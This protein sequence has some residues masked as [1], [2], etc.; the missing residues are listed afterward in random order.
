MS[1]LEELL[2]GPKITTR[3]LRRALLRVERERRKKRSELKRLEVRQTKTL[4]ELKEARRTGNQ[5]EVDYLWEDLKATKLDRQVCLREATV[6]NL[7]GITV[8]N[9][10]RG[11]QRLERQKDNTSIDRLLKRVRSSGLMAKLEREKIRQDEYLD[12]LRAIMEDVGLDTEL[13]EFEEDDPEKA[14]FLAEID[15]LNAA[16]E[17]GDAEGAQEVEERVKA[18]LEDQTE[19]PSDL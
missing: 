17:R 4:D 9:Y 15:M 1:F 6:L 16:E 14:A 8:K 11:L 7:E 12:E 5:L 18:R 10:L 3:E 13:D 2:G 19:E